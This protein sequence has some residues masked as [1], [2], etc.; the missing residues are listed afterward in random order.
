VFSGS[1]I[2]PITTGITT[3][4]PRV[5]QAV[6]ASVALTN[7][8]NIRLVQGGNQGSQTAIVVSILYLLIC[9][10]KQTNKQTKLTAFLLKY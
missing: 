4:F 8:T 6:P 3:R 9:T 2:A 7:Q 5:L 10:N 1:V